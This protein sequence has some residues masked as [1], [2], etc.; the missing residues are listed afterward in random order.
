MK[1]LTFLTFLMIVFGIQG[2]SQK[3]K[4]V[5]YLKNGS[6]IN[7]TLFE[8]SDNQYKIRTIDKNIFVF[9]SVE[10]DRFVKEGPVFE[11]R[12]KNGFG[13]ALESGFLVGSQNSEYDA[14]FS[15]NCLVNYT[16]N[17][18]NIF[19]VGS[20][21]EFIGQTYTPVFVEYKRIISD[22]KTTPFVFFRGGGLTHIAKADESAN[23]IYSTGVQTNHKGGISL[24]IGTGIS[25]AKEGSETYLSFAY[26]YAKTSYTQKEGYPSH[27]AKYNNY[28]N[29]L[30]VK[31]G[32]KF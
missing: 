15:F 18:K 22:R 11:G 8:I 21:V 4:D 32:F 28:Y 2:Y 31:L 13:F 17:V 14:P 1:K 29:R 20:G 9:N 6:V 12:K 19:G 30:E 25:W 26:R 3:T 5:I 7:G 16:T 10:V 24:G 23:S 27:D